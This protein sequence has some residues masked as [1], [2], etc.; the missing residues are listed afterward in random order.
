MKMIYASVWPR[1]VGKPVGK[2]YLLHLPNLR[3]PIC[4]HAAPGHGQVVL[5]VEQIYKDTKEAKK[6]K[7]CGVRLELSR[8]EALELIEALSKELQV[9]I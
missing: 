3:S 8:A 7:K 6:L 4:V 5:D 2:G 1:N 9:L